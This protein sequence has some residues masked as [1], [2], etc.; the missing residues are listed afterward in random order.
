[1]RAWAAMTESRV[2]GRDVVD[3]VGE[4]CGVLEKASWR[5]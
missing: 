4:V 2:R 1:M 3:I 5:C